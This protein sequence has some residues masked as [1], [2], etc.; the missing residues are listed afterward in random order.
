MK[1]DI[2]NE[3]LTKIT[4][5]LEQMPMNKTWEVNEITRILNK[6]EIKENEQDPN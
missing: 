6:S 5:L 1:L 3:N 2:S 4:K